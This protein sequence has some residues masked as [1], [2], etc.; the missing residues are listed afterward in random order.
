MHGKRRWVSRMMLFGAVILCM[1][2]AFPSQAQQPREQGPQERLRELREIERGRQ[3]ISKS[4]NRR[5]MAREQEGVRRPAVQREE[6]EN[7]LLPVLIHSLQRHLDGAPAQSRMDVIVRDALQRH[8]GIT[9]ERI[10]FWVNRWNALPADARER[11]TPVELRG[12]TP[13]QPLDMAVFRSTL[14]RVSEQHNRLRTGDRLPA[15]GLKGPVQAR[16]IQRLSPIEKPPPPEIV[17]LTPVETIDQAPFVR[18]G[19][20]LTVYGKNLPQSPPWSLTACEVRFRLDGPGT[21]VVASVNPQAATGDRLEVVTPVITPG[22]YRVQV[23]LYYPAPIGLLSSNEMGVHIGAP[24]PK[25]PLALTSIQPAAQYPGSKVI[26]NGGP[27]PSGTAISVVFKVLDPNSV[28]P[29]PSIATFLSSQQAEW[30]L[31]QDLAPG[32]YLVSVAAEQRPISQWQAITVRAPQY[33][34]AFHTIK[35]ID[36]STWYFGD[37]PSEAGEDEVATYWAIGAD[38]QWWTKNT[39]TYD[40]DDGTVRSYSGADQSVFLIDGS[41][42]EVSVY[43][44]IATK[45][46]EIDAGDAESASST[47]SFIGDVAKGVGSYFGPIGQ[48]VGTIVKYV[49]EAV[50]WL[51]KQFGG[52]PDDIGQVEIA[53]TAVELQQKT[54]NP[55]RSF[56]GDLQFLNSDATGSYQVWYTVTRIEKP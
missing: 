51:V 21:Q 10:Q 19:E 48:T 31:P 17:R 3:K 34:V 14:Q 7:L 1:A 18:H 8:P 52:E 28:T 50:A 9:R 2:A 40:F 42:G 33:R 36:E 15:T 46:M 41:A 44:T 25:T 16:P 22:F 55:T 35:C 20:T 54:A 6:E 26:L 4:E 43:L 11:I 29:F 56:E 49:L 12:L 23:A 27:F 32:Q 24:L 5:R 53:W 30:T 39:G 13:A 37:I 47:L 38:S 45:L